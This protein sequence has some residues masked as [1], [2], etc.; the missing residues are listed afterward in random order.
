MF[1]SATAKRMSERISSNL[2]CFHIRHDC[3][4]PSL[5]AIASPPLSWT[6]FPFR[7]SIPEH[8]CMCTQS[9]KVG[10]GMHIIGLQ[11]VNTHKEEKAT[12]YFFQANIM[13]EAVAVE[14]HVFMAPS[15]Q[16]GKLTGMSW[17]L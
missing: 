15:L 10:G 13:D 3:F 4:T 9:I 2:G 8:A 6:A 11:S 14:E 17:L 12:T 5:S 7:R 1:G 16:A